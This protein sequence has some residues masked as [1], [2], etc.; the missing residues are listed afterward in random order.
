VLYGLSVVGFDDIF[1][2]QHPRQRDR[3]LRA[4]LRHCAPAV[5]AVCMIMMRGATD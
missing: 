1:A 3:A 4:T 2:E 5:R